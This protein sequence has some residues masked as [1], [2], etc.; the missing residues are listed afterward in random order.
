MLDEEA[1]HEDYRTGEETPVS[2]LFAPKSFSK[3]LFLDLR[4]YDDDGNSLF[5]KDPYS[6]YYNYN[7]KN[8]DNKKNDSKR[9]NEDEEDEDEKNFK[10]TILEDGKMLI[11]RNL[12]INSG[13]EDEDEDENENT[14]EQYDY[15]DQEE[16]DYEDFDDI[17]YPMILDKNFIQDND[18][19]LDFDEDY[20]N[21]YED[22]DNDYEDYD[23][24]YDEDYEDYDEDNDEDYDDDFD[25]SREKVDVDEDLEDSDADEDYDEDLE[26]SDADEDYDNDYE[27]YDEDYDAD[28]S[29]GKLKNCNFYYHFSKKKTKNMDEE[30]PDEYLPAHFDDLDLDDDDID[31]L[32]ETRGEPVFEGT[33]LSDLS[34]TSD[35]NNTTILDPDLLMNNLIFLLILERRGVYI[36]NLNKHY[37]N[38]L[39]DYDQNDDF[40]EFLMSKS[41]LDNLHLLSFNK[42]INKSKLKLRINKLIPFIKSTLK[43]SITEQKTM[44]TTFF[45]KIGKELDD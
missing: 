37:N 32:M 5:G 41:L 18:Y 21:D 1:I 14:D 31:D 16:S 3:K 30:T 13:D 36:I 17:D 28:D 2:E 42:P 20:D 9:N 40:D 6:E 27:D 45:V 4:E 38:R 12:K 11:D 39:L 23:E 33:D 34:V 43:E 8:D 24:D 19:D 44:D 15:D 35:D 7:K 25:I 29:S 26:D 10:F 22:Y